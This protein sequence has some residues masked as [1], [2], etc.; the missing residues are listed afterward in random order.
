MT[1]MTDP[2]RHVMGGVDT[3]ADS[4]MVVVVDSA[5]GHVAGTAS[6]ANTSG[7]YEQ[8]LDWMQAH[9]VVDKVGVEGTGTYGAGLTR[10]LR[11][12]GVDVVEVDR[13]DRKTRRLRGKSDPVDAEAAAR[14][15]L[16]GTATGTPKTRDGVVEA[17]RV[18]KVLYDSADKDRTRALNQFRSL[19]LTAPE[20][21]RE[22][23]RGL[24][25]AQQ[26]SR[27]ARFRARD[28]ADA[29]VRHTCF[30]LRELARR[31]AAIEAQQ[32]EVEE[33]LRPLVVRHA[34]AL[35]GLPGAGVHT[36]AALLISA[37]DNPDRMR[38]EAAFA[39]LCAAAPIPAS[40]GKTTRH[41]LNR[42]GDRRANHALW[43]IALV[44]MSN[45]ER[46]RDYVARR[47]A[48][49]KSKKEIL[50]C[51]KRYI[52]RQAYSAIV[53]P[54]TDLPPAGPALRQLRQDRGMSLRA[55]A[56]VLNTTPTRISNLER[57]LVFDTNLARRA[58]AYI[59]C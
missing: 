4:H 56:D 13:P 40:S 57:E 54:P 50:R 32:T 42:G 12:E 23:L 41:R 31:I 2:V 22:P 34:P 25:I 29:V 44:R 37:G 1:S 16:A 10:H 26:L 51:L 46:T 18:L 28:T 36:A 30:V 17:M 5:T 15:A 47:T 7:G 58:H 19:L 20:D 52:A 21:I 27:A 53:A 38:S 14:A 24:P 48:E 43:R 59:T 3:H 33:R 6:F 35:V 39:N 55:V 8:L 49:G 45:D 9:G 11:R